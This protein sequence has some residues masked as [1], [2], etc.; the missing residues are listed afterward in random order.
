ML[1]IRRLFATAATASKPSVNWAQMAAGLGAKEAKDELF[2]LRRVVDDLEKELSTVPETVEAVDFAYWRSQIRTAG[3]VDSYA[4]AFSGLNVPHFENKLAAT[5]QTKFAQL[6]EQ[7]RA[8]VAA[9]HKRIEDIRG[10]LA[11]LEK[12]AAETNVC[13]FRGVLTILFFLMVFVTLINLGC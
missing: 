5:A 6:A 3:I 2:A 1:S 8:E 10:E 13:F 12:R 7:A 11:A 9:T 4:K